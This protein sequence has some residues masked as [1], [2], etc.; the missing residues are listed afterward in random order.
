MESSPRAVPLTQEVTKLLHK[1]IR[2]EGLE[3]PGRSWA[4]VGLE[5]ERWE[6]V[7][8]CFNPKNQHLCC[9]L[10]AGQGCDSLAEPV[11]LSGASK[12]DQGCCGVSYQPAAVLA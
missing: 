7:V 3:M 6:F 12:R 2:T 4:A 9:S 8:M 1:P 10:G 5:D 11:G